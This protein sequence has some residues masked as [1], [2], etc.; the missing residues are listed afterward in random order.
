MREF[1]EQRFADDKYAYGQQ[2]NDFLVSQ[3]HRLKPAMKVLAVADGEGRNG[4]WLAEQGLNVLSVDV[5]KNGLAKAQALAAERDVT[6]R[7]HCTD[8]AQWDWPQ[9]EYDAVIAIFIHFMPDIRPRLHAAMLQT[10][11]PGGLL[12]MEV[13]HKEQLAYE[14]GGPPVEA[15]LYTQELLRHDFADAEIDF[16]EHGIVNLNEGVY[17]QGEAS[18]IRML[19][20]RI[21]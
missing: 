20:K 16:M 21:N 10:L 17:H 7:T 2:P 5:S 11:K 19:V 3:R 14:S 6:L 8:L 1:W 18:T 13:F 4:V 15:M 9:A 12:V